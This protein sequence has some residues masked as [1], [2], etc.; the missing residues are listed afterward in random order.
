[1][2]GSC[3]SGSLILSLKIGEIKEKEAASVLVC[4]KYE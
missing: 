3:A 1:M 4:K 2:D